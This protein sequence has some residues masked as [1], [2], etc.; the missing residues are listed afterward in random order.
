MTMDTET[1]YL[2]DGIICGLFLALLFVIQLSVCIGF[3]KTMNP[4]V[5]DA[6]NE[7]FAEVYFRGGQGN[8]IE[9]LVLGN[10]EIKLTREQ[11][12]KLYFYF[13]NT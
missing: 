5:I 11:V 13:N 10:L 7:T 9:N 3:S 6:T 8:D 2:V 4:Q 1:F 12:K